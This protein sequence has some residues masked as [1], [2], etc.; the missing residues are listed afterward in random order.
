MNAS[1][2]RFE[3]MIIPELVA[4]QTALEQRGFGAALQ[5][6]LEN[7]RPPEHNRDRY[8]LERACDRPSEYIN[9]MFCWDYTPQGAEFWNEV[10]LILCRKGL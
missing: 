2:L 3:C 8:G 7:Y 1:S 10:Y 9:T 6:T 5:S 4:V